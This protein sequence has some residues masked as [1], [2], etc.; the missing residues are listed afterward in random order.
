MLAL[1]ALLLVWTALAPQEPRAFLW[2]LDRSEAALDAAWV[3]RFG[4]VNCGRAEAREAI[5]ARGLEFLVDNAAGRDELHLDRNAAS[6]RRDELWFQTRDD[7]LLVREPCLEDPAIRASMLATLERSVRATPR[8]GCFGLSLGDEVSFTPYGAPQDTC[9][10]P[11]CRVAWGE[12]LAAECNAGRARLPLD[13]DLANAS[14]DRARLALADGDWASVHAWL[15]RRRFTQAQMCGVLEGLARRAREIDST[16]RLGLMGMIGPSAFGGLRVDRLLPMLDFAECYRVSDARELLFTLREPRQ[17]VLQTIFPDP[18]APRATAWAMHESWMR[19]VDDFVLWS[20][21]EVAGDASYR[22]TLLRGI[23]GLRELQTTIG[24]FRP[25]PT[26][27]ALLHD[28]DSIAFGWLWDARFDGPTWPRRLQGYQERRGSRERSLRALL[29]LLEDCGAMPGAL[30]L[31]RVDASTR[32]RFPLLIANELRVLDAAGAARIEAFLAAGGTLWIQ[33]ELGRIDA[34]GERPDPP[35]V[36]R[37]TERFPDRVFQGPADIARYAE[38]RIGGG[39]AIREF[40]RA[41]LT[42]N[43]VE[44][45]PWSVAD[46]GGRTPWLSSWS[47]SADGGF[48]CA[49]LANWADPS[50]RE[51]GLSTATSGTLVPR[52]GLAIEWLTPRLG[53]DARFR[54]EPGELG[55]FRLTPT[56]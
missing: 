19:G 21:R 11:R 32:E 24:S 34:F 51:A 49:L 10:C 39:K 16:T 29:R 4:G 28:A 38:E 50:E 26:G 14:T 41:R 43:D 25:R 9:L 18:K 55:V 37:W 20:D 46:D 31:E 2:R 35:F 27:V 15:V 1:D 33:G 22:E 3:Q 48:S 42:A 56:K 12:Y 7:A 5:V 47:A 52:K 23:D 45:A 6:R 53:H 36:E 17:R 54:L 40:A 8:D 13:H 44:L 30:P